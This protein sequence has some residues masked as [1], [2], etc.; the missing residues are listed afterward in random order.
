MVSA[1]TNLWFT[2]SGIGLKCHFR[3]LRFLCSEMVKEDNFWRTFRE[4]S[5]SLTMPGH[6]E[7]KKFESRYTNLWLA[8]SVRAIEKAFDRNEVK[9]KSVRPNY[10]RHIKELHCTHAD[11]NKKILRSTRGNYMK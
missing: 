11:A 1:L 4:D 8:K 10:S 7:T 3:T 9:C 2:N 6:I 5:L